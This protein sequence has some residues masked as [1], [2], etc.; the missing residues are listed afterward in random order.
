MVESITKPGAAEMAGAI[1]LAI[2]LYLGINWFLR[3]R[4]TRDMEAMSLGFTYT[5]KEAVY[6]LIAYAL[7]W[8]ILINIYHFNYWFDITMIVGYIAIMGYTDLKMKTL[9]VFIS[10]MMIVIGMARKIIVSGIYERMEFVFEICILMFILAILS[11]LNGLASG[12]I[13]MLIALYIW[14]AIFIKTTLL[15]LMVELIIA[16]V[17]AGLF[18]LD[19]IIKKNK[20][21]RRAFVPYLGSSVYIVMALIGITAN[22][23]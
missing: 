17:S 4:L 19:N 12:D 22:M 8:A 7:G 11:I 13:R 1:F 15:V 21:E 2:L 3:T 10:N 6:L 9:Y 18:N 14:Q 20:K 16:L 5:I 23:G